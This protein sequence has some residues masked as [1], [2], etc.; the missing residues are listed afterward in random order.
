DGAPRARELFR[1]ATAADR[2]RLD[3]AFSRLKLDL[4]VTADDV[5]G[6]P[7]PG[8]I[9]SAVVAYER[10]IAEPGVGGFDDL[11]VRSLGLLHADSRVLAA[12]RDRCARLLI[13]E[14]QDL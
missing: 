2:G 7:L 3:L 9:A 6:D 13:D 5:A 11:V 12:W 14:A 1:E 8:P 4:R 10:A